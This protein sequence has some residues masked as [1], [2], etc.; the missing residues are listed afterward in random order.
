[1]TINTPTRWSVPR[2]PSL[3][4]LQITFSDSLSS[5]LRKWAP[6][7]GRLAVVNTANRPWAVMEVAAL[8]RA[9][10]PS[11]VQEHY[12]S[13]AGRPFDRGDTDADKELLCHG[14]I[15]SLITAL[16][17]EKPETLY[18]RVSPHTRSEHLV[19]LLRSQ[20]PEIRLVVEFYDLSCLFDRAT[21]E[22]IFAGDN[23][24]AEKALLGCAAALHLADGVVVKMGGAGF[25]EW[26]HNFTVPVVSYFPSLEVNTA[27]QP[28]AETNL[29][30]VLYAGS[31]SARELN[32]GI[33][34]VPGANF[35]KYFDAVAAL[36]DCELTI[37]NGVHGSEAED[38]SEKF[39]ALLKRYKNQPTTYYRRA[40]SRDKLVMHAATFDIGLCCAHYRDDVVQQVTRLGLP[41]RMM[42]Y[43]AAGL[44][45][46]IDDR[47]SFAAG[48]VRD[49]DAGLVV[50]AGDFEAFAEGITS[51]DIALARKGVKALKRYMLD[52]NASAETELSHVAEK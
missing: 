10:Q 48:L 11:S 28:A 21:L 49:F 7:A 41:N 33:G 6:N 45:I 15:A 52:C 16:A 34:S 14:D 38:T 12:Y 9:I 47:F 44:P 40:M 27:L 50:P 23:G 43:I 19:G 18:L 46:L 24:A 13:P 30:K 1:M 35:I 3:K 8:K 51:M 26:K 29:R 25:S 5:D 2:A 17:T 42:S 32:G 37:V 31:L 36:P 20:F 4:E 22:S 39:S